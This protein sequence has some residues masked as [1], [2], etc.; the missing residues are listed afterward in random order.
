MMRL[1]MAAEA[2]KGRLDGG[3][4]VFSGVSIDSRLLQADELFVAVRGERFNGHDFLAQA[5]QRGAAGALV[6]EGRGMALPAIRVTDTRSALGQLARYWRAQF[7]I[8][9]IGVTGSNGKTTVKG[10]IA[11]ILSQ[12]GQGIATSGNL[13]NDLGVP[14]TLLRIRA[15][16]RF[17]VVEMGMNHAGEIAYLVHL[18]APT[19]ALII[20]A[21]AAH[22]EG[23][24]SVEG[25]ARAKGEIFSGLP[26][27]GVAV[28][29][30]DDPHHDLWRRLA[31]A[32]AVRTFGFGD[33]DVTGAAECHLGG[34]RLH[35]SV[36]AADGA[37]VEAEASLALLGRHNALNALAATAAA[38]AAGATLEQV[39]A[40]I[41]KVR[42]VPGRLE[43]RTGRSGTLVINDTYNANPGSLAAAIAVL[44]SLPGERVLVLGDMMELG[45]V[46]ADRHAE[47][48]RLARSAGIDRLMAMGEQSALA[49]KS[50][51]SGAALFASVEDLNDA[52]HKIMHAGMTVLVKGSRS[53]RMER[54]VDAISESPSGGPH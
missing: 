48:G 33:A 43:P 8:P 46:A 12:G 19:V 5:E 42:A 50:F 9:V 39:V 18:A 17:A 30:R 6:Q 54:V 31:G 53:T 4:R 20:N 22:L 35:I 14:L 40:G 36:R 23:L 2:V 45:S 21:A 26:P 15:P 49:V 34:S 3:D 44:Q 11:S 41:G 51:G 24:G 7:G 1:S 25:V 10:M 37:R 13:N 27:H 16:D 28:I 38:L 52:L 29:N 47:A 32:R